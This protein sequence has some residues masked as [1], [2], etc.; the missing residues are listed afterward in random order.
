EEKPNTGGEVKPEEKPNTGGEVKPEEKPNTGGE[1]K[2]E[3]K[4]NTGGEV[5]P[6]E[7]P[8]TGGEVKPEEKPNTGG[9]VKPEEKP[10]TG[11]E[12]KP[13]NVPEWLETSLA[14]KD[15]TFT[16]AWYDGSEAINKA[17]S[18]NAQQIVKNINSKYGTNL[19]YSEVG[20]IVKLV[21]GSKEQFMLSGMNADDFG[22]TFMASN[23]A[24]VELA[25]GFVTLVNPNVNLD[26]EIQDISLAP[27]NI[28]DV[29]K[30]NYKIHISPTMKDQMISIQITKK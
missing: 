27:K 25:K 5:K 14:A 15:F 9:E 19:K 20:A 1:V 4:P 16:Q 7:K 30:G 22:I 3:E 2:P 12:T 21:D 10:N 29:E 13:V 17:A 6:E 23:N 26:Q 11:E 18:T 28:K 24:T 8:N